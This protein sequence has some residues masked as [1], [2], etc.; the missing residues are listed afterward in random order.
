[1]VQV[2]LA[3]G[4][5]KPVF[6][7]TYYVFK[8]YIEE[9]MTKLPASFASW[10]YPIIWI[11]LVRQLIFVCLLVYHYSFVIVN[12]SDYDET[13]DYSEYDE[14]YNYEDTSKG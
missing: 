7:Y 10:S 1:M 9:C 2:I 14:I 8:T 6:N 5:P 12:A 4:Y 13:Y 3:L 11:M